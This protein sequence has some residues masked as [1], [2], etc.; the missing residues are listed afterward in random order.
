[1]AICNAYRQ[2]PF[3]VNL[4]EKTIGRYPNYRITNSLIYVILHGEARLCI[5][6]KCDQA[7]LTIL[8]DFHES[9]AAGHPGIQK[10]Y[11]AIRKHFYWN[12]MY[13]QI[14]EYVRSCSVCQKNKP[15]VAPQQAIQP[16]D[17][18]LRRMSEVT[19]DFVSGLPTSEG[20]DQITVVVDRLTK[21]VLLYGS[22]KDDTAVQAA[23]SFL[24]NFVSEYGLPDK[25]ISD[26]DVKFTA[27]FWR[28]LTA[29]LGIRLGMSTA[30]HP[31]TD[32]QTERTNRVLIEML[33][34]MGV[35]YHD[36][37]M[38]KL[39]LVQ[40]NIN[41]SISTATGFTPFYAFAA[42][43]L[44]VIDTMPLRDSKMQT[45]HDLAHDI[46]EVSKRV[47][48][49]LLRSQ[50]IMYRTTT[51]FD[52]TIFQKGD[53]VLVSTAHFETFVSKAIQKN[54]KL[55]PKF[56]GPFRIVQMMGPSA[57]KL[58]LPR[59]YRAHPT[60]NT[61]Y[62]RKFIY[63][64]F[65][66]DVLPEPEIIRGETEYEVDYIVDVDYSQHKRRKHRKGEKRYLVVWK[67]HDVAEATWEPESNLQNAQGAIAAFWERNS[68]E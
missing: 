1:M 8:H 27:N 61:S 55:G 20:F 58:Q 23:A 41:N 64:P 35:A 34:T 33:R 57:A 62:L 47:Q 68:D 53:Y 67:G 48:D 5:P 29:R 21:K 18:P 3:Y 38:R 42:F 50:Q 9:D 56:V 54:R 45:M 13:K 52:P 30:F 43:N 24:N 31:Q 7:I 46:D 6:Q 22:R 11:A 63:D 25:I 10:C 40:F 4:T 65:K 12:R 37:W 2:D 36:N 66:R 15:T 28:E 49:E 60:I 32:G 59:G 19:M 14:E 26:R 44:R 51:S 39:K 17:V 16:L